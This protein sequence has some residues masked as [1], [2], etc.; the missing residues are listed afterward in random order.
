M[1]EDTHN[2]KGFRFVNSSLDSFRFS[3]C[4]NTSSGR[5]IGYMFF[6]SNCNELYLFFPLLYYVARSFR[7]M[8]T[9]STTNECHF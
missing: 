5:N 3:M 4:T 7:K 6:I 2:F 1:T 9:R 8:L